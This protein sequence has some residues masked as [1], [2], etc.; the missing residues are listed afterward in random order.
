MLFAI[1]QG[2]FGIRMLYQVKATRAAKR[3]VTPLLYWIL[4]FIAEIF[5]TSYGF[6]AN[7]WAIAGTALVGFPFIFYNI[8]V[9]VKRVK[10]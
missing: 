4:T 9:E 7:S 3:S 5:I 8:W 1:G 10:S 2:L 6:F